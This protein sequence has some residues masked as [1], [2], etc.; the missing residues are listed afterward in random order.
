MKEI[1]NG[2]NQYKPKV[3]IVL[4]R[5]N[6]LVTNM[7]CVGYYYAY[8]SF[9]ARNIVFSF[10]AVACSTIYINID[11][12][13]IVASISSS[14]TIGYRALLHLNI[15]HKKRSMY[16]L[17]GLGVVA[18]TAFQ[19]YTNTKSAVALKSPRSQNHLILLYR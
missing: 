13:C 16:T 18:G 3:I 6:V 12:V 5:C 4:R 2:H 11:I 10:Y 1:K 17:R 8:S 15:S 14:L 7:R 9:L 19:H